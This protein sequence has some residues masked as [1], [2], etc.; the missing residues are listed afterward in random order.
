MRNPNPMKNRVWTWEYRKNQD[1]VFAPLVAPVLLLMLRIQ[2][3]VTNEE[4]RTGLY[5]RQMWYP[6]SR[7]TNKLSITNSFIYISVVYKVGRN[8]EKNTMS[9]QFQTPIEKSIPQTYKY[10]TAHF[11]GLHT[12]TE[13]Q[14]GF[15]KTKSAINRNNCKLQNNKISWKMKYPMPYQI[16]PLKRVWIRIN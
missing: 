13:W 4:R 11:P 7:K 15:D 16:T 2:W 3:E 6:M 14:I 12:N 5:L 1:S 8:G 9:E 10:M